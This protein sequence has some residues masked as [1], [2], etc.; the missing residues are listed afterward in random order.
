V[1]NT[2]SA[3]STV[4]IAITLFTS[5]DKTLDA[6]DAT[7]GTFVQEKSIAPDQFQDLKVTFTYP[8]LQAGGYFVI[9]QVDSANA[10]IEQ[11]EGNNVAAS[12]KQVGLS[13]PFVDL[14]PTLLPFT[15]NR[16]RLG[17][18]EV[19]IKIRN[20]GNVQAS[21]DITVA[22][23]AI[24][25]VTPD[26]TERP[27]ANLGMHIDIRPGQT[28]TFKLPFTFPIEFERGTYKLVVNIDSANVIPERDEVN[29]RVVAFSSFNFA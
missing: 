28:K 21:G 18:N 20:N 25:D 10:V 2:G 1:L 11:N 6:G 27:I 26:P 8:Q 13:S 3:S 4:P 5:A 23:T 24:S 14:F 19:T 9:A 17:E 15:G 29:N 7:I 12:I 22:L 16:S